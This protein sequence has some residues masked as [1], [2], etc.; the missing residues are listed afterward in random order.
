MVLEK[1]MK[2]QWKPGCGSFCI[3][4]VCECVRRVVPCCVVCVVCYTERTNGSSKLVELTLSKVHV[5]PSQNGLH[6]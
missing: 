4:G 1:S 2:F 3:V 6:S 5:H